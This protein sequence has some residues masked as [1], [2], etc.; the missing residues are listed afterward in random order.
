MSTY[1]TF[2]AFESESQEGAFESQE[3]AFETGYE[4]YEGEDEQFL[5]GL[6]SALT[7]ETSEMSEAQELELATEL[8]EIQSEEELE[9]FLGIKKAGKAVGGFVRSP[10]GRQ[11]GG[12]LKGVAKKALPMVG[13]ALGSMVAP[14]IGTSIGSSLGSMASNLFELEAETMNEE[15]L[16][17]EVA[18]RVVRLTSAAGRTAARAPRNVPPARVARVAITQAARQHAPG[19]LRGARASGGSA[20]R[21]PERRRRQPQPRRGH[22]GGTFGVAV[23]TGNGNGQPP[24]PPSEDIWSEPAPEPVYA[25]APYGSR[26]QSGRWVRRGRKIVLLDI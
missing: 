4:T 17:L 10:V 24:A 5:G 8:L 2:E 19:L 11:L 1:E 15:E 23:P 9:E 26:A 7:G 12:I 13:G 20:R 16:E 14:G 22:S 21:A 18:R 6:L 25:S 3:G